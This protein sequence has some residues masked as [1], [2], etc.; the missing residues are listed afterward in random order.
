MNRTRRF[1]IGYIVAI[2]LLGAAAIGTLVYFKWSSAAV[3]VVVGVLLIPGRVQGH[4]WREFFRGRR[5]LGENRPQ[6]AIVHFNRFLAD[7]QRRPWLSKL[8]W[9]SWA[10]YTPS[11]EVM[12]RTNLGVALLRLG[13]VQDAEWEFRTAS[14]LDPLAPLPWHNLAVVYQARGETKPAEDARRR[15]LELGFEGGP[16][17]QLA[18][19]AGGLLAAVEGRGGGTMDHHG[20]TS[21]QGMQVTV[22]T[23][24]ARAKSAR[25]APVQSAPDARR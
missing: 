19:K 17:D 10:F 9:L 20:L 7:L 21:N 16:A 5:L 2:V 12:T 8:I 24:T 15:A 18:Q 13:Q 4:Y 1:K 14:E 22:W 3:V 23:V 25:S 11:I 6:D